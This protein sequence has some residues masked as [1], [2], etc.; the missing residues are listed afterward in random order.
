MPPAATFEAAA[1]AFLRGAPAPS[2]SGMSALAVAR[3]E[4]GALLALQGVGPLPE[5]GPANAGDSAER[6]AKLTEAIAAGDEPRVALALGAI[7]A[8][9]A[10]TGWRQIR[11]GI[12]ALA[13]PPFGSPARLLRASRLGAG[14][15]G[16]YLRNAHRLLPDPGH[17]LGLAASVADE[18]ASP[19]AWLGSWLPA[20]A[21]HDLVDTVA[22]LGSISLLPALMR[23]AERAARD[24]QF[25]PLWAI[26]DAALDLGAP[27]IGAA[28]QRLV[29]GLRPDVALEHAIL[30]RILLAAHRDEEAEVAFTAAKACD[31]SAPM[32][33][34]A[35]QGFGT[36]PARWR[37]R[38]ACRVRPPRQ[39]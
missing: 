14:S 19:L 24:D 28:A 29:I 8:A 17:M 16:P 3:D 32:R 30:G 12:E 10:E 31:G 2:R 25:A 27:D 20:A 35:I 13:F 9:S 33:Q 21:L 34:S 23:H 5:S 7:P 26:R 36:D 1:E 6:L 39:D 11:G 18:L 15:L 37:R 38:M 22:D 4:L